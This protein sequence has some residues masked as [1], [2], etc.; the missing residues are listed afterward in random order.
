MTVTR[1]RLLTQWA[2]AL[3]VDN[4]RDAI[5]A[6]HDLMNKVDDARSVLQ[7]ANT[8]LSDAPDP[9]AARGCEAAM[10]ALERANS[11]LLTIER[12]FHK[13]ERGRKG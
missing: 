7:K 3:G 13:H 12:R 8:T 2:Q 11:G 1:G 5:V 6:L 9:D 10:H 4:D